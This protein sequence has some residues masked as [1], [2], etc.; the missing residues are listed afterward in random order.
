MRINSSAWFI[1]AVNAEPRSLP[2]PAACCWYC[3]SLLPK[4]FCIGIGAGD[5]FGAGKARGPLPGYGLKV[6][7]TTGGIVGGGDN[8]FE[9]GKANGELCL[10]GEND[11]DGLI[12]ADTG[13][14]R[15]FN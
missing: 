8:G 10:T 13:G 6:W 11:I 9:D 1:D 7:L 12:C 3:A 5:G 14:V 15:G 4:P 2:K